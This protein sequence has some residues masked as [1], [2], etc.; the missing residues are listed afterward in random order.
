M[1]TACQRNHTD[2]AR[3]RR[4]AAEAQRHREHPSHLA[5]PDQDTPSSHGSRGCDAQGRRGVPD[6]SGARF[7]WLPEGELARRS[8]PTQKW[9]GAPLTP[10]ARAA[11]GAGSCGRTVLRRVH[12]PARV[13]VT[14]GLDA[15]VS[16]DRAM[17]VAWQ[18]CRLLRVTANVAGLI[19]LGAAGTVHEE[20]R[21]RG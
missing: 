13:V 11:G 1:T 2:Q 14:L 19:R 7:W 6:G 12:A 21:W 9:L 20:R 3:H 18:R 15:E 16:T 10:L 4:D 17:V 5:H 8:P